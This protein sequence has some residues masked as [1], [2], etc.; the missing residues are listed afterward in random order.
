VLGGTRII[1]SRMASVTDAQSDSVHV[2]TTAL[3]DRI[4]HLTS[5]HCTL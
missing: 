5:R 4:H 3:A 1:L 2:N